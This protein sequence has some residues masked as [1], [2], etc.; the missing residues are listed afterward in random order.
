M[1]HGPRHGCGRIRVHVD[2]DPGRGRPRGDGGAVLIG[3]PPASTVAHREVARRGDLGGPLVARD[4]PHGLAPAAPPGRRRRRQPSTR[5]RRPRAKASCARHSSSQVNPWG[6]W[7]ARRS[8]RGT[9]ASASSTR[10]R[11]AATCFTVSVTGRPGHD[12]RV[13]SEHRV[14][15]PSD[16]RRRR[17]RS[18][19]VVHEHHGD[20]GRAWSGTSARRVPTATDAWRV[21]TAQSDDEPHRKAERAPPRPP[22]RAPRER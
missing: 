14:H 21:G 22:P 7:T 19:R 18:G 4:D 13:T 12:R 9:V 3:R 11:R 10:L 2:P 17:E 6:V 16:Q 5:A 15:H 20:V 8:A 1:Q